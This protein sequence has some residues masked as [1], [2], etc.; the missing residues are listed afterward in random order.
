[1]ETFKSRIWIEGKGNYDVTFVPVAGS[2]EDQPTPSLTTAAT[3]NIPPDTPRYVQN[4]QGQEVVTVMLL[5]HE[6]KTGIGAKNGRQWEK[7]SFRASD[8]RRY[9]TFTSETVAKLSPLV[10]AGTPVKMAV[11]ANDFKS[12]DIVAVLGV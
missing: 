4:A 1:M 9:V 10:G 5:N 6:M 7:H 11:K 8:N 2:E 3:V 12:F